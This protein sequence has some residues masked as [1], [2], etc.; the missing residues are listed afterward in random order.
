MAQPPVRTNHVQK[1]VNGAPSWCHFE[2]AGDGAQPL[3]RVS[4]AGVS[5]SDEDDGFA[6]PLD[7]DPVHRVLEQRRAA[8]LVLGS[9][10]DNGR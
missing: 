3:D 8:M 6:V 7:R 5:P 10:Q 1:G 4:S 2:L 9:M